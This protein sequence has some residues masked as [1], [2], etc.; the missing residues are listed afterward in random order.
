MGHL[1]GVCGTSTARDGEVRGG[2]G[3]V[4]SGTL[5][6]LSRIGSPAVMFAVPLERHKVSGSSWSTVLV[7]VCSATAKWSTSDSPIFQEI[8]YK[9][10]FCRNVMSSLCT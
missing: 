10:I 8:D 6:G 5:G 7:N 4:A 2:L 3:V 1:K 9:A